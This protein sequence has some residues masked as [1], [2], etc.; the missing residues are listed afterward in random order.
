MSLPLIIALNVGISM[1]L[2]LAVTTV[3]A[4]TARLRAHHLPHSRGRR[5]PVSTNHKSMLSLSIS[6]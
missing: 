2:A 6:G 4:G 1:L 5:R 3:M